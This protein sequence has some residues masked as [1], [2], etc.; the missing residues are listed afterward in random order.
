MRLFVAIEIDP[1]IRE[2]IHEFVSSLRS[3]ISGAR[4]VRPEGLHITL[5]FLGNV[6]DERREQIEN[7][8]RSVRGREV[9][10][11][12]KQLG[13]F[14]NPRS[15]RVLWVGIEAGPELQQ[16]AT[17]VDQQMNSLGFEREKRAFSPHVTLARFN[18]RP[19]GDLGP[20][21]SSAQPGFGTMTA[22]EFHLYESKLSPQG[23]RYTKLASFKLEQA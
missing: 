19:E 23:S 5:K 4:W 3:K 14:P 8:L 1:G 9:T 10:L 20:L 15:A 17:A 16:L 18:Q 11:S 22:N 6:A 13:V 21:L 12:L 7:A 2:R